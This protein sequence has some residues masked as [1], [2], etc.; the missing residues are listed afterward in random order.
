M[1]LHGVPQKV[2]LAASLAF[3]RAIHNLTALVGPGP[4]FNT[5][6]DDSSKLMQTPAWSWLQTKN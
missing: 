6:L 1:L 4:N 5:L 3:A 2:K